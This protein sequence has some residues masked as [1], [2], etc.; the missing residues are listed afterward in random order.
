M[1]KLSDP[2][3]F[4]VGKKAA[5]LLDETFGIRTVDDLLRHYPRSYSQGMTVRDEGEEL[6]LAEGEH[7]TFVD[8]ITDYDPRMMKPQPG[9]KRREYLVVTLGH[10]RPKVTATFFNA[11]YLKKSLT[12]GTKVM[13]S[14]EVKY[15]RQTLQLT[16]PAFLVLDSSTGR[17]IMELLLSVRRTRKTTLVLVT[18]D[19]ELAALAD[20]RLTLRDGRPVNEAAE[21]RS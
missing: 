20:T 10:R 14:G 11:E 8:V 9:R 17:H 19:P 18:H 16:H 1:A 12:K 6:D 5:D 4:I 2:L 7:V 3:N 15:F 21:V 13:L